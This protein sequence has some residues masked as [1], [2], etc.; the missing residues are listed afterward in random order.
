VAARW[1][2]AGDAGRNLWG[3]GETGGLANG[4]LFVRLGGESVGS[5]RCVRGGVDGL[6]CVVL[7]RGAGAYAGRVDCLRCVEL[8]PSQVGLPP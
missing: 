4:L 7:L 3:S 5:A 6:R 2:R 1:L 8:L